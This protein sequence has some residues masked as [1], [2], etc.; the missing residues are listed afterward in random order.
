MKEIIEGFENYIDDNINFF[1]KQVEIDSGMI[2][3]QLNQY[4]IRYSAKKEFEIIEALKQ[5]YNIILN[6]DSYIINPQVKRFN[7][8]I[9]TK[10]EK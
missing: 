10:K 8:Y 7:N 2:K 3:Q 6:N 5:N 4:K 1:N 9:V